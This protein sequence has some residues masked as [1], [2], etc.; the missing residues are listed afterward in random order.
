V[1][2]QDNNNMQTGGEP[3][4]A[5]LSEISD[6][7]ADSIDMATGSSSESLKPI[8][9]PNKY[10][11][12]PSTWRSW[13]ET[14]RQLAASLDQERAA[15]LAIHLYNSHA[16]K[17]RL[18]KSR[19][20]GASTV[21][22]WASK[23]SW[24]LPRAHLS[25]ES[26]GDGQDT[27]RPQ[28]GW[29]AWPMEPEL[30]P[31]EGEGISRLGTHNGNW[32][33]QYSGTVTGPRPSEVL[34]DCIFG[35]ILNVA[36]GKYQERARD[37]T[38]QGYE[39]KSGSSSSGSQRTASPSSTKGEDRP[40]TDESAATRHERRDRSNSEGSGDH[41]SLPYPGLVPMAD[42][43]KAHALLQPIARHL[44]SRLDSLLIGLHYARESHLSSSNKQDLERAQEGELPPN[45]EQEPRSG[46]PPI[47][48]RRMSSTKRRGR[49]PKRPQAHIVSAGSSIQNDNQTID[50]TLDPEDQ[51]KRVGRPRKYPRGFEKSQIDY[52]KARKLAKYPESKAGPSL[53]LSEGD[54]A[55]DY[56]AESESE[57][58]SDGTSETSP[59]PARKSRIIGNPETKTDS[60]MKKRGQ[61]GLMDWS[62]LLGV[63]S[64]VGWDLEAV[65]RAAARCSTLFGEGIRFRTLAEG[66]TF[67]NGGIVEYR[68]NMIL[69][70]ASGGNHA[71]TPLSERKSQREQEY[72]LHIQ[73]RIN[74]VRLE[75]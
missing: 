10:T 18:W 44:M 1:I 47:S 8:D 58:S 61:L 51:E 12:P 42:D 23:E 17:R 70:L 15:D 75:G 25:S 4:S 34:E 37:L 26:V 27:F 50:S 31:R 6:D 13:T 67:G 39:G 32:R 64:M 53:G 71:R 7:A 63:A 68:P 73:E 38:Q 74:S 33:N 2:P 46:K 3:E 56:A 22:D 43:E 72:P 69:S 65:G 21:Q 5:A 28:K 14:E 45:L 52:Y 54:S 57:G 55:S 20:E 11:G 41:S 19:G 30:V 66:K 62:D 40:M 49:P 24:L 48:K 9:R 29:T 16:L 35:R 36:K 59:P 60:R